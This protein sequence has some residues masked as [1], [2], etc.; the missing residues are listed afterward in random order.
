MET[1]TAY[2]ITLIFDIV[3]IY[4]AFRIYRVYRRSMEINT[5]STRKAIFIN[6]FWR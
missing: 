6:R 1:I 3:I 4:L 5:E 2:T